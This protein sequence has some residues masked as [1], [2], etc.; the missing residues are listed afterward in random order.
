M[1]KIFRNYIHTFKGLSKE[2]WWLAFI[3]LI[4]RAGTMVIP[5]LSLYLNKNLNFSIPD[6]GWIMSFFGLGSLVGSWIG[7][8]LTDK[9]GYYKVMLV[10]LVLTGIFF[11]L[12]QYVTTFQGFCAGIFLV[13]L[14]ADSFRPAMFVA[15]SAYSKPENKTRSVTLIR[16]AINLGFSAGPAV[17]GLIITGIGYQGLFWVDGITC[18]LAAVLL[19]QVLHPK[20]A[21]IQDEVKVKNPISAYKDKPFW[22]FFI[23]MF[24]FGF[25]FLQYFSTMPLYYKDAHFLSELEIGLLMGFNGFFIFVFE[26]PLIKW[27]ENPKNSKIKL[28]AIGLFLVAISFIILNISSW[29]GILLIG[30]FLMTVGEMIAFPFSNAFAVERAKKGNQGEYMALYSIAFSLAHIFSHNIGMQL[31]DKFGFEFTWNA[32]T[33]FALLGVVILFLLMKLLKKEKALQSE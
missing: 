7:G 32:I 14:V 18:V 20:K 29:I 26:M 24:I 6:I 8:K 1:K 22:I 21:K 23:A 17:G 16:L 31:I 33:I 9:I 30:M 28:V 13:M 12:L 4:N 11:V 10:S 2:V 25:V 19:L 27:L 3:T 15:L 5:F